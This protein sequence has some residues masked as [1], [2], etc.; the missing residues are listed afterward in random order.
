ME[1]ILSEFL[2]SIPTAITTIILGLFLYLVSPW[3]R[4]K[5]G[6]AEKKESELQHKKRDVLQNMLDLHAE[7]VADKFHESGW[8]E[9]FCDMRKISLS[10]HPIMYYM[11]MQY[12]MRNSFRRALRI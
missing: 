3:I 7:R 10:G 9:R 11:N 2:K 12:F 8:L 6:R 4:I 1:F 5:L